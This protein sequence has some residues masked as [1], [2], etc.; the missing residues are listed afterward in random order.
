[1]GQ[2]AECMG[3]ESAVLRLQASTAAGW[4]DSPSL[5]SHSGFSGSKLMAKSWD[6]CKRVGAVKGTSLLSSP[7]LPPPPTSS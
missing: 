5:P 3:V 6:T 7:L 4:W 1:M 2:G